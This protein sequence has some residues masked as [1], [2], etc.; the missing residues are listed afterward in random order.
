MDA[1]QAWTRRDDRRRLRRRA[2]D[3]HVPAAGS[4]PRTTVD[5]GAHRGRCRR[6]GRRLGRR[7]VGSTP[8]SRSTSSTSS[9]FVTVVV[10]VGAR[11]S[12]RRWPATSRC[13]SRP[14]RSPPASG[15]SRPCSSSIGSSTR[16]RRRRS[17]AEFGVFLG[18]IA[19]A[20]IAY[21]GWASMQEEG[22][23]FGA[24]AENLQDRSAAAA[25]RPRLRRPRR[26][27]RRGGPPPQGRRPR[28]SVPGL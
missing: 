25:V 13:R 28:T 8:G 1:G 26:R 20:G 10:A 24:Q 18:L 22:T 27:R 6:R 9:C 11:E 4:A 15:S 7:H 3:R 14:A 19:A 21:G 16:R 2:L 23:S 17:T 5:G 12:R